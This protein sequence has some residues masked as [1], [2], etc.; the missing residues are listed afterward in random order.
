VERGVDE[1]RGGETQRQ[2]GLRLSPRKARAGGR[3]KAARR[4]QLDELAIM[5]FAQE[6]SGGDVF[7]LAVIGAPVP[8]QSQATGHCGARKWRLELEEFTDVAECGVIDL[9]ALNDLRCHC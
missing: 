2:L 8:A 3:W 7:E 9:A 5:E 1:L 6:R 4:R